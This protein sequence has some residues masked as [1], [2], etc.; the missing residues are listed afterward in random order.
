M[1]EKRAI[2]KEDI[3]KKSI[4]SESQGSFYDFEVG[5]GG[6]QSNQPYELGI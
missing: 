1:G 6:Q 3:Q 5:S 2:S 4:Y